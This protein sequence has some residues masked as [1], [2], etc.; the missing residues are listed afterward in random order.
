MYIAGNIKFKVLPKIVTFLFGE[1][2][3]SSK[4]YKY[5]FDVP[6]NDIF[7]NDLFT[8]HSGIETTIWNFY[9]I[10]KEI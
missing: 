4:V 8:K 3:N 1:I 2:W 5:N 6:W 10:I 9:L 7:T